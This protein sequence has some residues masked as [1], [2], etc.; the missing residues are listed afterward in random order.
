MKTF[1]VTAI[2]L[3]LSAAIGTAA[4]GPLDYRHDGYSV[5][6]YTTTHQTYGSNYR[7]RNN[8][9]QLLVGALLGYAIA[10]SMH[11]SPRYGYG[12]S[13]YYGQNEYYNGRVYS[14][15][16]YRHHPHHYSGYGSSGY[17]GNSGY[18]GYGSGYGSGGGDNDNG[19]GYNNGYGNNGYGY[20]YNYNYNNGYGD[21]DYDDND[22]YGDNDGDDQ[23]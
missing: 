6:G 12:N 20:G 2:G 7:H 14:R 22:G 4:A 13:D 17:Y 15:S 10:N 5:N 16:A 3:A 19:Y 8:N 11:S 21:N 23:Y 18:Y 9:G 1:T